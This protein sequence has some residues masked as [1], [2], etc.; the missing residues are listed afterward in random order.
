VVTGA[1]GTIGS[2]V[3]AR[4][5]HAGAEV[6]AVDLAAGP[7]VEA[8]DVLDEIAL[9][10]LISKYSMVTD[11]VH[12]AGTVHVGSIVQTSAAEVERILR[13]NLLSTFILG[14]LVL[15]ALPA[16]GTMTIIASQAARHGAA[17][18]GPYSAS[19][20]GVLRFVESA[21]KE[22][23]PLGIRVNAVN[24]GSVG[25][26]AMTAV[27][28]TVAEGS[29]STIESVRE[30]YASANPLGGFINADGVADLCV[31]LASP[32]ASQINGAAVDLDGGEAPG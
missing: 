16:G 6:V 32:A 5:R 22:F 9:A 27:I 13:V 28:K 3:V 31:F 29:N 7:E 17:N 24:P 26:P 30:R 12:A 23:G 4:M 19:K 11:L 18:W 25:G 21:A 8:C 15:P 2:A 10:A 14:R 1:A 20:A